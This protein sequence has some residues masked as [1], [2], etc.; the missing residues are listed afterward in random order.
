MHESGD[1][2]MTQRDSTKLPTHS[3]VSGQF[4][5][6]A[7]VL[8][9]DDEPGWRETFAEAM[10]GLPVQVQ[11]A[12]SGWHAIE[13]AQ[14]KPFPVVVT[15]V[16]MSGIDGL[17]LIERLLAVQQSTAFVLVDSDACV[18]LRVNHN[19][20][21]AIASLIH[22]PWNPD[23]L[24]SVIG[25]AFDLHE[26]RA[27][28]QRQQDAHQ[29]G[30]TLL[31][32][33]NPGDADVI[34][35]YL[36]AERGRDVVHV[37]RLADAVKLLHERAFDVIVTDLSLPDAR[38]L[39]TIIRLQS[40][41]PNSAIVA[42]SGI[43]DSALALQVVQL[44][45]QDFLIK[46]NLD[47]RILSRALQFAR[48]R[49]QS[50]LRL[51]RL[52][53]FDQLTGLANRNTFEFYADQALLRARRLSRRLALLFVDLDN[54]KQVNDQLG[55]DAGDLL[56]QEIAARMGRIVR[57][58]DT[59]AR[60]GGDEFG[61]VLT[62]V[63]QDDE[64]ELVASRLNV[65]LSRPIAVGT[66]SAQVSASIGIATFPDNGESLAELIRQADQAMYACKRNGRNHFTFAARGSG[67][68]AEVAYSWHS[69]SSIPPRREG[70]ANPVIARLQKLAIPD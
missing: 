17:A 56:L 32:E 27:S 57:E 69:H 14:N 40:R 9:V 12:E 41:A 70:S 67:E 42:C 33:D 46:G 38:G 1:E 36:T 4:P 39:D 34:L 61:L 60:F 52:A 66:R 53:H 11:L 35:E 7:R 58:Y 50:E 65:A 6:S 16:R 37:T 10:R 2:I 3:R 18:N 29:P 47:G 64:I 55:H 31:I 24:S 30:A 21:G 8:F 20:D 26:N 5:A 59:V 62:D 25:Q 22:K 28:A 19:V 49:K 51:L 23:E 13:L 63:S 43:D 15:A 45:A 44:G 54:F 48:E 68:S